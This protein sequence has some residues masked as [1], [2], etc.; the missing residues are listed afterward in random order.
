MSGRSRG[1][2]SSSWLLAVAA[3]AAAAGIAGPAGA[4]SASNICST[5]GLD[6]VAVRKANAVVT[7]IAQEE[8]RPV[9][10]VATKDGKVY[11]ALYPTDDTA[12][13]IA[14]WE[15]GL[16]FKKLILS[17]LGRDAMLFYTAAYQQEAVSF[18]DDS[19]IVWLTTGSRYTHSEL[20]GLASA[21]DAKL[22]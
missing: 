13:L 19:H 6:S 16:H 5:L 11:A 14:S 4:H 18:V 12:A 10:E 3:A 15:Y 21:I 2:R 8:A 20:L 17:G 1:R 22:P 7:E 9:C